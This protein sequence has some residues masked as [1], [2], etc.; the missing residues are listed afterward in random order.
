M[1]AAETRPAPSPAEIERYHDEANDLSPDNR[2]RRML[3][4]AWLVEHGFLH[5]FEPGAAK[6]TGPAPTSPGGRP[7]LKLLH[8]G[9][10]VHAIPLPQHVEA[11]RILLGTLARHPW[12]LRDVRELMDVG[13]L[14]E[15]VHR[16]FYEVLNDLAREDVEPDPIRLTAGLAAKLPRLRDAGA[17][18]DQI[19]SQAGESARVGSLAELI[20]DKAKN[21]KIAEEMRRF[22]REAMHSDGPCHDLADRVRSRIDAI[23]SAEPAESWE[24]PRLD[25]I[26]APVPFPVDVLP[27]PMVDLITT[28]AKVLYCP[29]D[30]LGLPMLTTAGAGVGRSVGLT[31]VEGWVEYPALFSTIVAPPGSAKTAALRVA[32]RPAANLGQKLRFNHKL[33]T[34]QFE[35]SKVRGAEGVAPPPQRNLISDIT[36]EA[37]AQTL[38]ENPGGLLMLHDE[39]SS[40]L[41]GMNQYKGGDGND[42]EFFL[43]VWSFASLPVDRKG[44]A[45]RE[46]IWL[47][48][49]FLA[50]A[51]G[52]QPDLLT[53]LS[54]GRRDGF[55]DRILFAFPDRVARDFPKD[56]LP[57]SLREPWDAAYNRLWERQESILADYGKPRH[58]AFTPAAAAKFEAWY[59]AHCKEYQAPLFPEELE[60]AW[61]KFLTYAPRLALILEQL[62]WAFYGKPSNTPGKVG[63]EAVEGAAALIDYF[64]VQFRRFLVTATGRH[65]DN[66]FARAI[67]E[68]AVSRMHA[69]FTIRQV[70]SNYRRRVDQN[71]K[72]LDE[73][74]SWLVQRNA[75]RRMPDPPRSVGR[76]PSPSFELNPFLLGS[77]PQNTQ[78][79]ES[80]SA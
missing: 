18:V 27:E 69:R 15:E 1:S 20:R 67:L 50:L 42:R 36:V 12:L 34:K 59:S 60:G 72:E 16:A 5:V 65:E 71:P 38:S 32:T 78:Y 55:I 68:W 79:S 48:E 39:L 17:L 49:P 37:I 43:K 28:A 9:Q 2:V 30:F 76:S 13:D 73:A 77:R 14:Y 7:E 21:R 66:K 35:Q 11:E 19:L 8:A 47:E 44:Q 74:L 40:W 52:I 26:P 31:V 29:P 63:V 41:K 23:V 64:K 22:E 54:S 51:G 46:P 10:P 4:V 70:V 45:N 62:Q 57:E 6:T 53:G 25:G 61:T 56:R 3:A 24:P 80:Q 75:I 58:V 33:L